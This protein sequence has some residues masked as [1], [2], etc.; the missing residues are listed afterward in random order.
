MFGWVV[1]FGCIKDEI[2]DSS[3]LCMGWTTELTGN[4]FPRSTVGGGFMS[5]TMLDCNKGGFRLGA[6][7][8]VWLTMG[9][10]SETMLFMGS[11]GSFLMMSCSRLARDCSRGSV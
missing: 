9:W 4:M 11:M 10:L 6:V 3:E 8:T 2:S 7:L 5:T 1:V